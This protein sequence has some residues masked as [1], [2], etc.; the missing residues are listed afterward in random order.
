MQSAGRQPEAGRAG[1]AFEDQ[2]AWRK[3]IVL[4][5]PVARGDCR[6]AGTLRALAASL[7]E[8]DGIAERNRLLCDAT[9][10]K[11]ELVAAYSLDDRAVAKGLGA[12]AYIGELADG[13]GFGLGG[14]LR[15]DQEREQNRETCQGFHLGHSLQGM[16]GLVMMG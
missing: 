4:P 8:Q 14:C 11:N 1:A 3:C 7:N 5:A 16:E 2:V 12:R 10:V 6:K 15:N 13:D 9:R